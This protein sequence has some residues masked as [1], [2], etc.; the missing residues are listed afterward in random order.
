MQQLGFIKDDKSKMT[1][2]E[3][4]QLIE[5]WKMLGGVK[6]KDRTIK[7]ENLFIIMCALMNIKLQV[8]VQKHVEEELPEKHR[9]EG[10]LCFD[11]FNNAHFTTYE[12]ITKIHKKFKQFSANRLARKRDGS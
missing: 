5:I 12:D 9:F 7:A 10:F 11:E 4:Q 3:E 6:S 1:P 8:L 2:T